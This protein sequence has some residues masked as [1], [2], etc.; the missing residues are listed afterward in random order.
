MTGEIMTGI[1]NID[2]FL[3]YLSTTKK[4]SKNTLSAYERDLNAFNTY[5]SK[6]VGDVL[7][8]SSDDVCS[9]KSYLSGK[10]FSPSSVS[11]AMSSVRSY[12]KFLVV[13]G[14]INENPSK[15]LKND[16]VQKKGIEVLSA[17]E[18]EELL[19]QPDTSTLK[20]IRDKAMLELMYATGMKVTE[21][22]SLDLNDINLQLGFVSCHS[23]S[24]QKHDRTIFLYPAAIKSLKDYLSNSRRFLADEPSD[25]LFLNV[26]GSRITRQGLWKI[27]KSYAASAGIKKTITPHTLRHSFATHLLENG[28]DINDIKELL[29]HTDIA[30]TQVY[31][32]YLKSKVKNSYLKFHPRA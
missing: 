13:D 1:N 22:I 8:A 32:N 21:L 26:N 29:G 2:K 14:S 28:A 15:N 17:S 10:G 20:G 18:I 16:K 11:R 6:R 19:A 23:D 5:I 25:A 12:Y 30:S 24:T 7:N 4:A 31:A 9:Y 27:L 3:S